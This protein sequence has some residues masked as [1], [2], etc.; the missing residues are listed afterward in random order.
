M[1]AIQEDILF[2]WPE[3]WY[4]LRAALSFRHPMAVTEIKVL[5]NTGYY[6]CP[7]CLLTMEREFMAFCD[8]CGQCLDWKLYKK[9]RIVYPKRKQN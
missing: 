4:L 1:K 3:L 2:S 9:A 7:Y 6:V 8:R 5:G